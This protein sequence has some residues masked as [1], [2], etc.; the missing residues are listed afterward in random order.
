MIQGYWF[1]T[2]RAVLEIIR[3]NGQRAIEFL[4]ATSVYEL[5]QPYPFE[6]LGSMYPVYVRG[7]AYLLLHNGTVAAAEFQKFLITAAS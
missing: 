2:I 3:G 6:Y 7:Q 1:P 4:Q 5:R